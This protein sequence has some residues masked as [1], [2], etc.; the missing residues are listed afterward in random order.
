MAVIFPGSPTRRRRQ[1]DPRVARLMSALPNRR[2]SRRD[3]VRASALLSSSA[4]LAACGISGETAQNAG[5]SEGAT[6][7][8]GASP[9]PG[10]DVLDFS[11]WP[12][13]IDTGEDEQT[14]PTL[15][16][17]TEETG[18]AVNYYEDI[19][20]NEEY[21]GKIRNQLDSGQPIGRDIIVF[22]DWMAGRVIDLGWAQ[23]LDH[24]NIP[25]MSNLVDA[26][27]DV[28]FDEGRR[29]SLPWQ[30]G[31]TGIGLNPAAV[32]IEVTSINDLFDP[33]LAGRVTMLTE[34][35]DTMGLLMAA[36]GSD[37]TD[38][39]FAE[40]EEAID[41]LQ[42]AVDDGQIRQFTGND[43][44]SDLAAGNIAA[45]IAWSGDV[46]Q[47]QFDNPELQF[48]V[49][50]EGANLWSDNMLIPNNAEHKANAEALMD[51][52]YQPDVAAEIAAWVNFITPVEGAQEAM[53]EIDP[54]LAEYELIFPSEEVLANTF[55]FK[56]LDEDE[57]RRYQDAFQAV[58]GA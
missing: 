23:E 40:Y 50:D 8:G 17:F 4:F 35:R 13:Y 42:Q 44:T 11:N 22:T 24:D 39:T 15:D 28:A 58:I 10:G 43:Y 16:R 34:M 7:A 36:M 14:H 26:L 49:P 21:F 27:R 9:A 32:D 33:A 53:A 52:V 31:M 19:N 2:M 48:I 55:Q 38:H 46:I 57:E 20:S 18:I 30:S 12:L 54:D 3:F 29:Y 37:P 41:R 6:G 56:Q 1:V 47:L 25:N 45:A 5:T 51:F